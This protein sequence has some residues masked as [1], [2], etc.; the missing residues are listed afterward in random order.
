MLKIAN[1]PQSAGSRITFA[2]PADHPAGTVSVVGNFNDWTPG[3]DVLKRRSNGTMSVTVTVPVDYVVTFRYL[4][5]NGWWFDEPEADQVDAGASVILSRTS[6]SVA[7]VKSARRP[8]A[9][10]STTR[11]ASKASAA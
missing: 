3:A 10:A 9:K 2:L 5:E 1:A 6:A 7:A 11:R 4:G 8:A